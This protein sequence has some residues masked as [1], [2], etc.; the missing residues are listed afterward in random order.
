MVHH[1]LPPIDVS[2]N[3]PN[4]PVP[5]SSGAPH[6]SHAP[7]HMAPVGQF[8]P[9]GG[10]HVS[11]F[12]AM[13]TPTPQIRQ[14]PQPLLVQSPTKPT[15]PRYVPQ[16][17]HKS[18][19]MDVLT[20]CE[21][22][23]QKLNADTATMLERGDGVTFI[24]AGVPG[25]QLHVEFTMVGDKCAH[26]CVSDSSGRV[27]LPAYPDRFSFR[28]DGSYKYADLPFG[29]PS[30]RQL[31]AA[32][33]AR[34]FYT[35]VRT[36]ENVR[37][38]NYLFPL[39]DAPLPLRGLVQ[40]NI[41]P[42]RPVVQFAQLR[43]LAD[44]DRTR[45]LKHWPRDDVLLVELA[46]LGRVH[47]AEIARQTDGTVRLSCVRNG[48]ELV[49]DFTLS[50]RPAPRCAL[51]AYDRHPSS[52]PET[53][54]SCNALPQIGTPCEESVRIPQG[55]LAPL[56]PP[57]AQWLYDLL[58]SP[59][60]DW[61]ATTSE[62]E[63]GGH[64]FELRTACAV[65]GSGEYTLF[66]RD[67]ELAWAHC[68]H[69]G[70][71]ITLP[72][73]VPAHVDIGGAPCRLPSSLP[74]LRDADILYA[75]S[76]PDRQV[77]HQDSWRGEAVFGVPHPRTPFTLWLEVRWNAFPVDGGTPVVE[78]LAKTALGLQQREVIQRATGWNPGDTANLNLAMLG[79]QPAELAAVHGGYVITFIG[80]TG[81]PLHARFAATA[82]GALEFHS[83]TT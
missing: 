38:L 26:L 83:A 48:H 19:M 45:I 70:M 50:S 29:L 40:I 39:P 60:P 57:Y 72:Q 27:E 10:T 25:E 3:P 17:L 21:E 42:T 12:G 9:Q 78:H 69:N 43:G 8:P 47:G 15:L 41:S 49:L 73:S 75:L 58:S 35:T 16:E 77:L 11:T 2:A 46:M 5:S 68:R 59:P 36:H 56:S 34:H 53:P 44:T 71:E 76:S 66:L 74:A 80:S 52:K 62:R 4:A 24:R 23:L 1:P 67:G 14:A 31:A 13:A 20:W 51:K 6:L 79:E 64:H 32:I 30:D 61:D 81:A 18:T 22:R 28:M 33:A 7:I 63:L 82:N 65:N 55:L 37:T 54:A